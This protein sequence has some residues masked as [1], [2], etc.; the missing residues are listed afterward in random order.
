MT[1][2]S[3]PSVSKAG[4]SAQYMKAADYQREYEKF[5]DDNPGLAEAMK[6]QHDNAYRDR[7]DRARQVIE[8]FADIFDAM[9]LRMAT[10]ANE[11]LKAADL[12]MPAMTLA[13]YED[14]R[15]TDQLEKDY[16]DLYEAMA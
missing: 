10:T 8:R 12:I 4:Q 3:N 5:L 11:G 14:K 1:T 13:I 16:A 6:V 15:I 9:R 2:Y 7:D